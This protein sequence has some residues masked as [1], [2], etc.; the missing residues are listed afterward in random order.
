[1]EEEDWRAP[2]PRQEA[3]T[4][5]RRVGGREGRGGTAFLG[6]TLETLPLHTAGI[7]CFASYSPG[8]I[9]ASKPLPKSSPEPTSPR[10]WGQSWTRNLWIQRDG[11]GELQK[12]VLPFGERLHGEGGIAA[13]VLMNG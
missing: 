11:A 6:L 2:L 8:V 9:S 4:L 13:G 3:D 5:L 7:T 12:G 10:P 1:M